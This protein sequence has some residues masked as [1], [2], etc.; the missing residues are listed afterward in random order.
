MFYYYDPTYIL[1]LIGAIVA[2]YAQIKVST[3]YAKWQKVPSATRMTGAQM[4]RQ[5]L[6]GNGC[7]NVRIERISGKLTDH[8][9][10]ENGVLR[11]SSEVYSSGS[12]A[13]LGVAAH[14]AGH[15]IQDAQDYAPLRI[16]STMVPIANIGS[17]ASIPLFMLGLILSWE[18]L[19]KIGIFCFALAVLFYVVTLPVEFNASRRAIRVIDDTGMLSGEELPGARSVLRA[20][21][22]TYVAALVV[23]LANLLRLL[24]IFAGRR[25]D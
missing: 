21:A 12:I 7:E 22:M 14:E 3:T 16:R 20:A 11:L 1:I 6:D 9:D 23:S 4:A 2:L 10:P 13:A 17:G 15:A 5:I 8:Y 24:A 19:V 18:P 25:D